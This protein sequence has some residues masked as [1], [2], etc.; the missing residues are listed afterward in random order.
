M[1]TAKVHLHADE[2]LVY[3]VAS[4]L[5]HIDILIFSRIQSNDSIPTSRG[6]SIEKVS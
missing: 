1:L 3:L 5:S 2:T 4:S 6:D